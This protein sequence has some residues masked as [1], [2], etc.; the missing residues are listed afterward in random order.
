MIDAS[1]AMRL[2]S[3]RLYVAL[4]LIVALA[5]G[6]ARFALIDDSLP[7]CR[8]GDESMWA[9]RALTILQTGDLN[10]HRFTKPGAH[11]Y[12]M[13]A[14]FALGFV[15]AAANLDVD[16]LQK[17]GSE[18]CTT[19]E[20]PEAAKVAKQL[21]AI[22]SV[23]AMIV[24]GA[25]AARI[26]G[27]GATLFLAPLF[28]AV[29]GSY[30]YY[31]WSYMN[32]NVLGAFAIISTVAYPYLRRDDVPTQRQALI[33]GA[34][35]GL[36]L[37]TKYNL[38]LIFLPAFT[39]FV[40]Y[41]ADRWLSHC[42]LVVGIALV[43][44]FA[45]T[46]YALLDVPAFVGDV[47][48]EAYHYAYG[49]FDLS[50][51]TFEPGW[52]IFEQYFE[53]LHES[54][55][56]VVLATA[57]VGLVRLL[58]VDW[59]AALVTFQF[60]LLFLYYMSQQRTFFARNVMSLHLFVG[61]A[62]AVGFVY[63]ITLAAGLV[64]RVAWFQARRGLAGGLATLVVAGLILAV[65]PW[66]YIAESYDPHQEPRNG[67]VEWILS[68]TSPGRTILVDYRLGLSATRLLDE[69]F[70]VI[71]YRS[72]AGGDPVSRLRKRHPDAFLLYPK[73]RQ[74]EMAAIYETVEPRA[75][76]GRIRVDAS[77]GK[78]CG[79]FPPKVYVGGF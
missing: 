26:S 32:T 21:Y 70:E 28:I 9:T 48:R 75:E 65:L 29:S 22:V 12:F 15:R 13:T 8:H 54:F 68:N 2:P 18:V 59:R 46:P 61:I 41:H 3:N 60:P 74:E 51:H 77:R 73:Y 67:A 5:A 31:S 42:L 44:F 57:V 47:G 35:C 56:S 45:I 52:P 19:Y 62:A 39:Y 23:L 78:V 50:K 14:G 7:Y 20:V 6:A 71:E 36:T 69:G 33:L 27:V 58:V 43:T 64:T 30:L 10:P 11:V 4:L 16:M 53:V 79:R 24:A 25:L 40:L 72:R 17:L 38:F 49:H 66:T 37:A 55:G 76:F 63:L 34:L 1:P